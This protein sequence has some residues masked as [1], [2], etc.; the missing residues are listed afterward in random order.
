VKLNLGCGNHI[1]SGYINVD[2]SRRV[3][4]DQVVDLFRYPW[5]WADN[6]CDEFTISHLCEHIPHEGKPSEAAVQ[7]GS[8]SPSARRWNELKDYDGF[9]CFF[10]E[11]WRVAAPGA[12]V[13]IVVPYGKTHEALQDPTHT[14]YLVPQSFCYVTEEMKGPG[15]FDYDI[16]CLFKIVSVR[17]DLPGGMP[18]ADF[19]ESMRY[20]WDLTRNMYVELEAIK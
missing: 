16:P 12:K 6:A 10:G 5:P 13:H 7:N 2:K 19:A 11:V 4:A 8:L 20:L 17:F 18:E 14:R 3:K 1:L 15:D 9:F